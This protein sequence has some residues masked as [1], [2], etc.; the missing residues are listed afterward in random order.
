MD[1]EI[2]TSNRFKNYDY[3]T[4][5][6]QGC[7]DQ[8]YNAILYPKKGGINSWIT[9]LADKIITPITTQYEVE[10][11]DIKNKIITFK[12][13]ILN[14]YDLLVTTIPFDVFE[15]ST[16]SSSQDIKKLQKKLLCNAVVNFNL[17]I[18]KTDVS[19]KHWGIFTRKKNFLII[20]LVL[21]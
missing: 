7:T 3:Q 1:G 16:E 8:G 15:I 10:S 21:S 5:Q 6:P 20:A 9:K 14:H 12:M 19:D 4:L 18:Q 11:I 13:V 17:G 2:C